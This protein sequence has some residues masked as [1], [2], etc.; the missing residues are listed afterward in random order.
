M[1]RWVHRSSRSCRPR[2]LPRTPQGTAR[3]WTRRAPSTTRRSASLTA[4]LTRSDEPQRGSGDGGRRGFFS[5]RTRS[6]G[7]GCHTLACC[8]DLQ[9]RVGGTSYASF[10]CGW[11]LPRTS[12]RYYIN[13][14]S[15]LIERVF[16]EI[17][18]CA[19]RRSADDAEP[20]DSPVGGDGV[21][22]RWFIVIYGVVSSQILLGGDDRL[23]MRSPLNIP[24]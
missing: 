16:Y 19:R 21:N 8:A 2:W 13:R 9:I 23:M 4:L 24:G 10:S 12:L 7:R 18:S 1:I 11:P 6:L 5:R 22:P 15:R 3:P 20:F 17:R 14:P